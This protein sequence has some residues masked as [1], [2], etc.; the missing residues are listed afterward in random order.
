MPVSYSM[1]VKGIIYFQHLA[2]SGMCDLS[3]YE[4]YIYRNSHKPMMSTSYS[5]NR[6]LDLSNTDIHFKTPEKEVVVH[7]RFFSN[8][9]CF[10]NFRT[11]L[12]LEWSRKYPD[13]LSRSLSPQFPNRISAHHS[14]LNSCVS[15]FLSEE[16][17]L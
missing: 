9:K 17:D 15:L 13:F 3:D 6:Q 1:Y 16:D 14:R 8:L 12:A 2:N 4:N 5:H 10:F 7:I 11:C